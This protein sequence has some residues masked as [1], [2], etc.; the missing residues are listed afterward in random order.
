MSQL[1]K[2]KTTLPKNS[3]SNAAGASTSQSKPATGRKGLTE[4]Q[5]EAQ[6]IGMDPRLVS[7]LADK[8]LRL[9]LMYEENGKIFYARNK[10]EVK[11]ATC[12]KAGIVR[13]GAGGPIGFVNRPKT[14]KTDRMRQLTNEA[15]SIIKGKGK[16][17][18]P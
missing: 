10:Q 3:R 6:E 16:A 4:P 13:I 11:G 17:G 8:L 12:S 5:L 14:S 2:S 15:I 7:D 1:Q 18:K 9:D